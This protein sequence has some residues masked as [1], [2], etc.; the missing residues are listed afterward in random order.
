VLRLDPV[1]VNAPEG[2]ARDRAL[3]HRADA[4]AARPF[5]PEGPFTRAA[6]LRAAADDHV[7][8]WTM[9]HMVADGWSIGIFHGEL[10]ALYAALARGE[11]AALAPLPTTYGEHARRQR[12]E[13]SG[14]ALAAHVGYWRERFAGAPAALELPTDRPRPPAPSGSGASV[15]LELDADTAARVAALAREAGVTPFMVLLAAFQ[16]LLSRWSGQDDVVVG[17]PIA[18][19]TRPE[20]EPLIGYFANTLALRTDLSGDASFAG[21]LARVRETTL[22]A[23]EHQDL[24]FE[25]LVEEIRPPRTLSHSPVFQVLFNLQNAE[26]AQTSKWDRRPRV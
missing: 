22:G 19:R 26:P 12:R 5:A 16:L 2:E 11:P 14:D 15:P 17:T 24:P 3:I 1:P 13:L 4:E 8:L 20:V 21:L 23:Y 7:L 6:L 25:K 9:H 18:N 10:R